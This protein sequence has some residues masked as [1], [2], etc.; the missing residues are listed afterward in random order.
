[1]K[2]RLNFRPQLLDTRR[3]QG[4]ELVAYQLGR[5][6]RGSQKVGPPRVEGRAA[7][8]EQVEE[9]GYPARPEG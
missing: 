5:A 9:S 4:A 8:E 3:R 2:C 7:R 6:W 1:M